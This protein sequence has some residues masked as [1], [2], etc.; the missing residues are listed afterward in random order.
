MGG[1]G[2]VQT[3]SGIAAT[4]LIERIVTATIKHSD[5]EPIASET[6]TA[7]R[8]RKVLTARLPKPA[9]RACDRDIGRNLL[10]TQANHLRVPESQKWLSGLRRLL[11]KK[12]RKHGNVKGIYAAE[13]FPQRFQASAAMPV[14]SPET[15]SGFQSMLTKPGDASTR[16]SHA[17]TF[18]KPDRS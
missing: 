3:G 4:T 2:G 1:K 16:A 14:S 15:S 8:R 6:A 18:G 12:G 13:R 11:P 17:R 9:A 5:S 10:L 7:L